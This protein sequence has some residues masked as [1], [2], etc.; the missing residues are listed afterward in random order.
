MQLANEKMAA[1]RRAYYTSHLRV[2]CRALF[3]L[4][5]EKTN[6]DPSRL[7]Q[8]WFVGIREQAG[9]GKAGDSKA[10]VVMRFHS[11]FV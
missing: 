7:L 5:S 1:A 2:S 8:A 6:L 9:S 11:H 10:A 4:G 3:P